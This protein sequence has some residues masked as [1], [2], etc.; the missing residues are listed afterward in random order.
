MMRSAFS[1]VTFLYHAPSGYTT[2]IGPPMQM[3]KHWT[4]VRYAGPCGPAMFSSFMRRLTY[5]QV[6]APCSGVV[7]SGP[8]HTNMC[9][10]IFPTPNAAADASGEILS[11]GTGEIR[12][13]VPGLTGNLCLVHSLNPPG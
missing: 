3:R 7:Q 11:L 9:R 2:E 10:T 8:M 5:S 4:F 13:R 6:S 12:Q 1:G